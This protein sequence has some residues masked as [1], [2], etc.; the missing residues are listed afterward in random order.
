MVADIYGTISAGRKSKYQADTSIGSTTIPLIQF[1]NDTAETAGGAVLEDVIKAAGAGVTINLSAPVS[2]NVN[3]RYSRVTRTGTGTIPAGRDNVVV[4]AGSV[5][6]STIVACVLT[7]DAGEHAGGASVEYVKKNNGV[8]FTLYLS[9][10]VDNDTTFDYYIVSR[11]GNGTINSG[12]DHVTVNDA[13]FV[14][15]NN[16]IFVAL[17]SNPGDVAGGGVIEWVDLSAKDLATPTNDFIVWLRAN[18]QKRT[19]FDYLIL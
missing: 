15:G 19:T 11:T 13:G 5:S 17:T 10:T 6:S 1:K 16:L 7:K 14:S 3:Y 9:D 8:G 18:A 4:T 2:N 12:R